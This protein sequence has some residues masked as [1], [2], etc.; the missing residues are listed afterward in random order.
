M[1]VVA[2]L[3]A[4]VLILYANV[5]AMLSARWRWDQWHA[6]M[7]G[8]AA[9]AILLVLYAAAANLLLAVWGHTTAGGLLIGAIAGLA[10]LAVI[11]TLT[12]L[13]GQLGRDIVAS[14]IGGVSPRR[15]VYRVAVQV[16]LTTVVCE[17]FMFRG[18]LYAL[19]ARVVSVPWVIALD[20]IAF[21]LWHLLLQYYGSSQKGLAR[22]GNAGGGVVVYGLLGLLLVLVRQGTGGLAPCIVAHGLLDVFMF[23]GMYVR[24]AQLSAVSPLSVGD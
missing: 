20:A 4:V 16:A 17:E 6:F 15:F 9:L 7:I 10:P 23:V 3:V 19:L 2:A 1:A 21:G 18:V 24:R 12:F 14:G 11:L 22:W 5:M 8:N 13:P